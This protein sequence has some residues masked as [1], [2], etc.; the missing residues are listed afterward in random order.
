MAMV[1]LITGASRGIGRASAERLL[2]D[3]HVVY[4]GGISYDSMKDLEDRGLHRLKMDVTD[5]QAVNEGVATIVAEQGRIDGLLANAGYVCLGPLECVPIAE[6]TANFEVNLFGVARA[7]NAVLPHMRKAS[8]GHIVIISSVA[9]FVSPPGMGWYTAT[10]H[11]LEAYGNTLR[12]EVKRFNIKVAIIQPG[13]VPTTI[14]GSSLPTLDRAKQ[15]ASA[16]AY[17]EEMANLRVNFTNAV[18]SGSPVETISNAVSRAF[19]SDSPRHHY[20][21]NLRDALTGVIF[22]RFVPQRLADAFLIIVFT[23]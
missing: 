10:K 16:D 8:Q 19:A 13:F 1:I 15:S 20:R 23:R 17:R 7:V 12:M 18:D 2:A 11:A 3:G 22:T 14:A 9:G 21:P 4:G 6:A 5:E